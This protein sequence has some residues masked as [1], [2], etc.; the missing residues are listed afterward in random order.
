MR[1][2]RA[3]AFPPTAPRIYWPLQRPS[4]SEHDKLHLALAQPVPDRF[5]PE[6]LE[7]V[8][9]RL[10][11]VDERPLLR[12]EVRCV[13]DQVRQVRQVQRFCSA[14]DDEPGQKAC[15][16]RGQREGGGVPVSFKSFS[17]R[18]GVPTANPTCVLFRY[19]TCSDSL[20]CC[21]DTS[22]PVS[23]VLV[24]RTQFAGPR[25]THLGKEFPDVDQPV[26]GLGPE[27]LDIS[28]WIA[29]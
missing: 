2:E 17:I 15:P 13:Q 19:S 11:E 10:G 21:S 25:R 9:A 5:G 24:C 26:L 16:A 22:S 4:S 8:G 29:L 18:F 6:E 14:G 20:K 1:G 12:V 27:A 7:Q 3:C 23:H 28:V